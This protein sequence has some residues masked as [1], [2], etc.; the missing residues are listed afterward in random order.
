MVKKFGGYGNQARMVVLIL[1][2]ILGVVG[3][4][5][6]FIGGNTF[7]GMMRGVFAVFVG[8]QVWQHVHR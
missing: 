2:A 3:S 8:Y 5:F 1:S 6:S 7:N 4:I